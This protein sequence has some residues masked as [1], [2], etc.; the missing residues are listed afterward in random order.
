MSN[1]DDFS[2]TSRLTAGVSFDLP[3]YDV[4]TS[5]FTPLANLPRTGAQ[6]V[7]RVREVNF[8]TGFF[9]VDNSS[10]RPMLALPLSYKANKE[11]CLSREHFSLN[12]LDE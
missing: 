4:V 3:R 9:A 2:Y 1:A 6:Q 12:V 7:P 8:R 5:Y 10:N 11:L